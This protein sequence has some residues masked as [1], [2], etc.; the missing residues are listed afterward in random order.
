MEQEYTYEI[1]DDTKKYEEDVVIVI[2]D[3]YD[4]REICEYCMPIYETSLDNYTIVKDT[5]VEDPKTIFHDCNYTY[6]V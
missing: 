3:Y 5:T 4:S 1:I 6:A 2:N